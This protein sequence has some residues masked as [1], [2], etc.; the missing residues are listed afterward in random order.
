MLD[1]VGHVRNI[2]PTLGEFFF[3]FHSQGH[4]LF[5]CSLKKSNKR[6]TR[7]SNDFSRVE[8]ML[9]EEL[10]FVKRH[11]NDH[12]VNILHVFYYTYENDLR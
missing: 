1:V 11:F 10:R 12:I 8:I 7:A 4:I 9:S 5:T 2:N 6:I 3:I